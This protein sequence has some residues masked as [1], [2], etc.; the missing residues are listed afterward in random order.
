MY[1]TDMMTNIQK[2]NTE[3]NKQEK[4]QKQIDNW[5]TAEEIQTIYDDLE[6]KTKPLF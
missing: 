6:T 1:Q 3:T 2:Y 5:M 4:N